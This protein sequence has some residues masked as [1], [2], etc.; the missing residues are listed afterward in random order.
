[1][2]ERLDCQ[3]LITTDPPSPPA[4]A[5]LESVKPPNHLRVPSV[6]ELLSKKYAEFKWEKTFEQVQND[7]S[8]IM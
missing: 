7:P 1:M 2:F 4:L 3:T 6:N 5:V 8:V